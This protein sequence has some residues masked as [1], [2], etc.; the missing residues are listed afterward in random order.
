MAKPVSEDTVARALDWLYETHKIV[1]LSDARSV[2][3]ILSTFPDG[4]EW[5]LRFRKAR[6]KPHEAARGLT[7]SCYTPAIR[8]SSPPSCGSFGFFNGLNKQISE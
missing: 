1:G 7:H 3:F 8:W 4:S 2:R 5:G 6:P